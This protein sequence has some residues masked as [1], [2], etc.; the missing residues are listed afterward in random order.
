MN[1]SIDDS[2]LFV[3]K[4]SEKLYNNNVEV[5]YS[6]A[7]PF[8][9]IPFLKNELE[10]NENKD[11]NLL[12]CAQNVSSEYNGPFTG[13]I[14]SDM[15]H[16][17]G[18][19]Y[20][21]VGH[22]ERRIIFNESNQIINKKIFKLIEKGIIP[23]LAFG[24]NLKQHKNYETE[25]VIKNQLIESLKN[26]K[27]DEISKIILAYEPIWSIGTGKVADLKLIKKVIKISKEILIQ[28]YDV[29]VVKNV[30]FLYGGSVNELNSKELLKC[31]F[32]DGVLVGKASLDFENFANIILN[33]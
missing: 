18:V 19:K 16:D 3:K 22:S 13:E 4:L 6:I 30:K 15:L 33:K 31:K 14:S 2:I 27:K 12:L 23:V 21:I 28:L 9:L 8:T 20:C 29:D 11:F 25:N 5:D 7:A 26:V 24:E 1:S 17:L 10:K 32:I